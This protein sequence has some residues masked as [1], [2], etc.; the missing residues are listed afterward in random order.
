[1]KDLDKRGPKIKPKPQQPSRD[2][3]KLW[4]PRDLKDVVEIMKESLYDKYMDEHGFVD[5]ARCGGMS[6]HKE[7]K[8]FLTSL[9]N[10]SELQQKDCFKISGSL[11]ALV[12]VFSCDLEVPGSSPGSSHLQKCRANM[13][14]L[15]ANDDDLELVAT[16]T[17]WQT[18]AQVSFL[19]QAALDR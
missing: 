7:A 8:R 9:N 5:F 1:M 11:S 15:K 3:S 12:E 14:E 13:R 16:T 2:F 6:Q 10:Q 18:L 19:F 4:A 17:S